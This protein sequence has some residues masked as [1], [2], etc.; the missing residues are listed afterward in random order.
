MRFIFTRKK[1]INELAEEM[2][3]LQ[4]RA[5]WWSYVSKLGEETKVQMVTNALD[6]YDEVRKI[7]YKLGILKKTYYEALK[8]YDF[9]ESCKKGYKPN[10]DLIKKLDKEFCEPYKKKRLF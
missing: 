1:L 7:C 5:D 3:Y 2:A 9:R 10:I 6:E 4:I 8:I